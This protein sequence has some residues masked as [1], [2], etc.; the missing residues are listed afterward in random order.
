MLFN[1]EPAPT[2]D[3]PIDMLFACHGKVKRFCAQLIML[4][5]YVAQ[6]GVNAAARDAIGQIQTYFNQAAPLHHED[7]EQDFFPALLQHAPQ[8]QDDVDELERQHE[9]LHTNWANVRTHLDALLSG[10]LNSVDADLM[11]QFKQG[12]DIHIAIEESLF[13]LGRDCIPVAQRRE[14][15]KVMATRRGVV[16]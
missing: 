6:N 16:V 12:Y 3:E 15:G 8:A 14:M 9:T 13:E 1:N 4:P 2:W 5:D 7:E 11:A 10:S